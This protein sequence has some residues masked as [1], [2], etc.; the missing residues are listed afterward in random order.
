LFAAL[1]NIAGK[2]KKQG[3]TGTNAQPNRQAS[4]VNT[5]SDKPQKERSPAYQL[6]LR[7]SLIEEEILDKQ[8]SRKTDTKNLRL[9][10]AVVLFLSEH[11]L[12][13]WAGGWIPARQHQSQLYRRTVLA[14]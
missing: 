3:R 8:S 5:P 12:R 6:W 4:R 1:E 9:G 14:E 13:V 10:E 11:S 2:K 7:G